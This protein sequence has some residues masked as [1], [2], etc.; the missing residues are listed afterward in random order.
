MVLKEKINA[1]RHVSETIIAINIKMDQK[2]LADL[3]PE[4]FI[5][6]RPGE[7][8]VMMS[9]AY[10][11]DDTAANLANGYVYPWYC[12]MQEGLFNIP[13]T[14][15]GKPGNFEAVIWQ[16]RDWSVQRGPMLG[17]KCELAEVHINKFPGTMRELY[18]PRIGSKVKGV[19]RQHGETIVS[20]WIDIKEEIPAFPW[21]EY[22][23]VYGRR[24]VEDMINPN[25]PLIDDVLLEYHDSEKKGKVYKGEGYLKLGGF[26][27][28]WDYEI[29]GAYY[30][31]IGFSTSGWKVLKDMKKV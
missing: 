24:K 17:Y 3:L 30:F 19:V 8:M 14:F 26:M 29:L 25:V 28:D 4:P 27:K 15:E 16:N 7:A 12:T 9:D 13:C 5:P 6:N 23:V 18:A 31:D 2:I 22:L 10:F 20:A 11:N 21:E 1:G